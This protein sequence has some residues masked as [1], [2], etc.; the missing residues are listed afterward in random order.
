MFI[1]ALFS[2]TSLL[3]CLVNSSLSE[4]ILSNL[5]NLN[6]AAAA[7]KKEED[8]KIIPK[9]DYFSPV[10]NHIQ[11]FLEELDF[12]NNFIHFRIDM[13]ETLTTID[14][15]I[16]IPGVNKED[17]TI[18]IHKNNE[19]V[20]SVH[21]EGM[22]REEGKKF[23]KKERFHGNITRTLNLPKYAELEKLE[24]TY[25]AGVLCIKIPKAHIEGK[26]R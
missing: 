19:L 22:L 15:L 12:N 11:R 10:K 1:L 24:A 14:I 3:F 4:S 6:N 23:K 17:I 25:I 9:Y 16:D 18:A 2:L 20:I 7:V 8:K 5:M 21:K 26:M 13:A